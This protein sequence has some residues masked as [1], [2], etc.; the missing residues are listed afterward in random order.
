M[1]LLHAIIDTHDLGSLV[2]EWEKTVPVSKNI[3][4]NTHKRIRTLE[5][6]AS[7]I[8][9]DLQ[10]RAQFN[11]FPGKGS[12]AYY[13]SRKAVTAIREYCSIKDKRLVC[14]VVD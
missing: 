1:S 3:C 12:L 2:A 5:W 8:T 9:R 11:V 13:G 6:L 4:D 10:L 7:Q 14:T